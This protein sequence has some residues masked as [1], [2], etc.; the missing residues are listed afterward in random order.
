LRD[1]A[2]A[3]EVEEVE[4]CFFDELLSGIFVCSSLEVGT[5]T[6]ELVA[7]TTAVA[8]LLWLAAASLVRLTG[9]LCALCNSDEG[10]GTLAELELEPTAGNL[11]E[12]GSGGGALAGPGADGLAE[13]LGVLAAAALYDP[14][15]P[16]TEAAEGADAAASAMLPDQ[17]EVRGIALLFADD[18]DD[19]DEGVLELAAGGG[20]L[21]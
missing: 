7:I 20:A 5:E 2:A 8:A 16:D 9:I 6:E 19:D 1:S 13:V 21:S 15:P 12:D 10:A 11:T 3:E 18:D 14:P 17:V 4:G